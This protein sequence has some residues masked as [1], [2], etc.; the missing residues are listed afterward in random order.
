MVGPMLR[1]GRRDGI[2]TIGPPHGPPM[3]YRDFLLAPTG[4]PRVEEAPAESRR[5]GLRLGRA[6]VG[7]HSTCSAAEVAAA[8]SEAE[9]DVVVLR[10]PADRTRWPA[11]LASHSGHRVVLGESLLVQCADVPGTVPPP[12]D[13]VR[14]ESA[15]P[16]VGEQERAAVLDAAAAILEES[17]ADHRS[18]YAVNPH[19]PSVAPGEIYR[20][21]I[22]A[23][24]E[25]HGGRVLV[26]Y[27]GEVPAGMLGVEW[28]DLPGG[29]RVGEV[30]LIGVRPSHRNR[31]S[32]ST[33][34]LGGHALLVEAGVERVATLVQSHNLYPLWGL[35]HLGYRPEFTAMTVHLV[36]PRLA[37][38]A[39]V[40]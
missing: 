15:G 17:F 11:Q 8:V 27:E 36:H 18:H 28:Y 37:S 30:H 14:F 22:D 25:A 12:L 13:A 2:A 4:S 9:A 39:R 24:A 29:R 23:I 10:Y 40:P 1:P 20:E 5:F 32:A 21:W 35:Q 31:M 38:E 34:F 3:S 16:H 33:A 26:W 6:Y 7:P 19:L